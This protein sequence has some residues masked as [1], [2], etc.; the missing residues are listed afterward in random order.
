VALSLDRLALL[1][2]AMGDVDRAVACRK[3]AGE[4]NERL[5]NFNLATGSERQKFLFWNTFSNDSDATISL[6]L[7]A[8]QDNPEASR[9]ALLTILCRQG[10]AVEAASDTLK[11]LSSSLDRKDQALLDLWRLVCSQLATLS[12]KAPNGID[13]TPHLAEIRRLEEQKEKLESQISRRSAAFRAQTRTVTVEDVRQAL[14]AEAVFVNFFTY[15]PINPKDDHRMR[16]LIGSSRWLMIA[17]EGMLNLIP[18]AALV[19]E[20]NRYLVEN[21]LFTYLT[22]GRDLLRLQQNV[23]SGQQPPLIIA[24]PAFDE[25]PWPAAEAQRN[26][27]YPV[28]TRSEATR[29]ESLPDMPWDEL[30]SGVSHQTNRL[31]R[32]NLADYGSTSRDR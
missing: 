27:I 12:L 31:K 25:I 13:P 21:Y 9:L 24:N 22:S 1:Y 7:Q 23:T 15:S 2:E 32:L 14:P 29:G 8:A 20:N 10:R 6:H 30:K 19:D 26:S 3:R 16:R 17:P 11:T 5:L 28:A 18:F 4:I